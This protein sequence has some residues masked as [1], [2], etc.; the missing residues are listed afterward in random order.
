MEEPQFVGLLFGDISALT[1]SSR[2]GPVLRS[3]LERSHWHSRL[4]NGSDY[5]LPGYIPEV[6]IN[7]LVEYKFIPKAI[8][9]VL[10]EI[11]EYDPLL[12]D[13][14]LKRHVG[15]SD[16]RFPASMFETADFFRTPASVSD[17]T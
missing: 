12:F 11:R 17:R 10:S 5:P 14:V 1:E 13:F 6:S 15:A 4:L 2:V 3:V 8:G 7:R 16:K 9:K